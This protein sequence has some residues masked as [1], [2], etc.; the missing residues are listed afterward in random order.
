MSKSTSARTFRTPPPCQ[1][2]G[3]GASPVI[4]EAW[5]GGASMAGKLSFVPCHWWSRQVEPGAG[6]R[7][8]FKDHIER[9]LGG[10]PD[11]ND[12]AISR[13]HWMNNCTPGVRV[14]FLS[15]TIA[16]GG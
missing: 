2:P 7:L 5:I 15:V 11:T 16:T 4:Q 13:A 8:C 14:R 1:D 10:A 6:L 3:E 9:R 12:F